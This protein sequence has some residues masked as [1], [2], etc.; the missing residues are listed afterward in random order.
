MTA[1]KKPQQGCAGPDVIE[2]WPTDKLKP[3]PSNS[4]LHSPEQVD[5]IV[6]SLEE[7]GQTFPCLIDE[8][9]FILAGEGRWR[10]CVKREQAQTKVIVA[11]GWSPAKK[12]AYIIVDN[13]LGENSTWDR[14]RLSTE[15]ANLSLTGFNVSILGFEPGEIK[16]M[17][18]NATKPKSD[19]EEVPPVPVVPTTQPGDLWLLGAHRVLCGDATSKAAVDRLLDG[20]KPHLMVTDPPYGVQYDPAWRGK[21]KNSDGSQLS[22]GKNRAVGK[23][24]NDERADWRAAWHHFP[25]VVAYVWHSGKHATEVGVSLEAAKF[26]CRSQIVWVK[27]NFVVGRAD[28][29]W[30]HEA[31]FYATKQDSFDDKWRFEDEHEV[32]AYAVK[33]GG[34]A[35]WRGGRKQSTVWNIDMV[36]N[37]TGHGT[38]KPVEC[39]RRPILNNSQ[40]GDFVYDPF[41]GSGTTVIAA[42]M[43]GRVC[44]GLELDPA[45][46]D[47]IVE[48]W[49][50]FTGL[51]PVLESTGKPFSE[52]KAE[53]HGSKKTPKATLIKAG[54]KRGG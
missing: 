25:G 30:G 4:R 36:K 53:R 35:S 1:R 19:P 23:V 50:T 34:T 29:H 14:Q 28:Y 22:T 12:R 10:A 41:L 24:A 20:A 11:R 3:H 26:L 33:V 13:K 2:F 48:R 46:V 21:V 43:E 47:V 44:L 16:T 18:A 8:G 32:A 40:G 5:G 51:V 9:G 15:V 42:Q 7:F 6:A 45:Y 27:N 39:M 38:Q 31:A 52:V 17:I 37:D 54:G 49:A